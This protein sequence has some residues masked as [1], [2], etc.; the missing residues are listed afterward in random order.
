MHLCRMHLPSLSIH[1]SLPMSVAGRRVQESRHPSGD[2]QNQSP[3]RMLCLEYVFQNMTLEANGRNFANSKKSPQLVVVFPMERNIRS[4]HLDV[5]LS[6][7][8]FLSGCFSARVY[9]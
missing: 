8:P 4:D 5:F 9:V 3:E 2:F 6:L 1:R 7:T